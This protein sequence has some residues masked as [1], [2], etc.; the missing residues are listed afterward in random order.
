M[1][2]TIDA[3]IKNVNEMNEFELNLMNKNKNLQPLFFSTGLF[4]LIELP[5]SI[6][7]RRGHDST[8]PFLFTPTSFSFRLFQ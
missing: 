7:K 3:R 6:N 8:L 4:S 2:R 5:S 1:Y